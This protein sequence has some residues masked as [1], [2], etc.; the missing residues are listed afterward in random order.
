MAPPL[1][2]GLIA[3]AVH[4]QELD[5]LPPKRDTALKDRLDVVYLVPKS[6]ALAVLVAIAEASLAGG[7]VVPVSGLEVVRP[8]DLWVA[9]EI[10][11]VLTVGGAIGVAIR[12]V[13][14]YEA[15]AANTLRRL[16]KIPARECSLLVVSKLSDLRVSRDHGL[17]A[18]PRKH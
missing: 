10:A 16:R 8:V 7:T 2:D 13:L 11:R 12:W 1:R 17:L 18:V 3:M 15:P 5:I 6:E 14:V 9:E 4:T